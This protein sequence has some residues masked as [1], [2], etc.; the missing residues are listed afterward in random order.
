M[1]DITSKL[2]TYNMDLDYLLLNGDKEI[3]EYIKDEVILFSDVISK[4]NKYGLKQERYILLTAKAIYNLKKN[5]LKRRIEYETI[6][7]ITCTRDNDEFIIHCH[8][9]EHDYYYFT[10]RK[11]K[12]IQ[13]ISQIYQEVNK[14]ALSLFLLDAK[15]VDNYVT[16]KKEKK[17]DVNFSRMPNITATSID[18]FLF[19]DQNQNPSTDQNNK[20]QIVDLKLEDIELVKV[21]GRGLYS[22]LCLVRVYNQDDEYV[23]KIFKKNVL[24]SNS[25]VNYA[26]NEAK[27][28]SN[29]KSPFIIELLKTFKNENRVYLLMPFMRGGDMYSLLKKE[30][31]LDEPK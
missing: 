30:I 29:V 5:E 24:L 9:F 16:T 15:T 1:A 22:K 26:Y 2:T 10:I 6:K 18:E 19:G 25:I 11:K 31:R 28:L 23:L 17:K 20:K 27:V 8:D 7:G 12:I 3:R 14:K 4:V 13:L 21:I